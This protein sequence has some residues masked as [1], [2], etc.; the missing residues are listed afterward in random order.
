MCFLNQECDG[1]TLSSDLKCILHRTATAFHFT[2]RRLSQVGIRKRISIF[3]KYCEY[4]QRRR[5]CEN[6]PKCEKILDCVLRKG[7]FIWYRLVDAIRFHCIT[8]VC[9]IVK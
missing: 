9:G 5:R 8:N 4:E 3:P 7:Y 2:G 1:F 6:E